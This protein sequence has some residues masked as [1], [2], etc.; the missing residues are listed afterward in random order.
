MQCEDAFGI[1]I[2]DEAASRIRTAGDLHEVILNLTA[3]RPYASGCPSSSVF[4]RCARDWWLAESIA[5]SSCR[6]LGLTTCCPLSSS[7]ALEAACSSSLLLASGLGTSSVGA[8]VPAGKHCRCCR[9]GVGGPAKHADCCR[10][11][12]R[13]GA[14][15][16]L[17]AA[18]RHEVPRTCM[19]VERLVAA[20]NCAE[21]PQLA[22][23]N[24]LEPHELWNVLRHLIAE[25]VGLDEADIGRLRGSSTTWGW[26][27]D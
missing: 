5:T 3:N 27:D 18:A 21:S 19:T 1:R 23:Q 9:R 12:R 14:G 16:V 26:T 4:F 15:D 2:P 20:I 8:L 17:L 7:T 24:R 22:A 6:H 13:C 25:R 10:G 11:W